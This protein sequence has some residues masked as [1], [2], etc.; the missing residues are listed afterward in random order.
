[1]AFNLGIDVDGARVAAAAERA[2]SVRVVVLGRTGRTVPPSAY[3]G[4][5]GTVAVGQEAIAKGRVDRDGLIP[6]VTGWLGDGAEHRVNGW[7]VTGDVLVAHIL[8]YVARRSA[9]SGEELGRVTVAAP[10]DWSATKVTALRDA[11]GLA[12]MTDVEVVPATRAVERAPASVRADPERGVAV[13][14]AVLAAGRRPASAATAAAAASAT[15]AMIPTGPGTVPAPDPV[16]G[17]LASVSVFGGGFPDSEP[18]ATA[19]GAAGGGIGGAGGPLGPG[20]D[21]PPDRD[22]LPFYIAGGVLGV[23]LLVLIVVLAMRGG[24]DG[25]ATSS[26]TTSSSTSSTSTSTSTSTTTTS[27]TTSTTTTTVPTS[28]TTPPTTTT[29]RPLGRAVLLEAGIVLDFG[30]ASSHTIVFGEDALETFDLLRS[31]LG[32]PD[33][34]TGWQTDDVELCSGS[35]TRRVTW[36]DLEIVFSELNDA[37]DEPQRSFEQWFVDSPGTVP[38]GLATLDRIGI[39]SLVSD[40]KYA[41]PDLEISHPRPGDEIGFFTSRSG[42]DDLIAGFTTDTTDTSKVIQMWAGNACQR[43]ADAD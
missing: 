7:T 43:L 26:S 18:P 31:V 19:V 8:A 23:L 6:D 28:T 27:T 13:G 32:G 25:T 2:A 4:A 35:Q 11:A 21:E 41:Y 1:V 29:A 5:D 22:R 34:D 9:D 15:Q 12:G 30:T 42:D 37:A 14:A 20:G 33:A 24:D 38:V 17:A 39:G 40:L 36:G 3:V 16:T 10:A